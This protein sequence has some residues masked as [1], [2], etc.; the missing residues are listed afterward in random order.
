[1]ANQEKS[2]DRSKSADIN[3]LEADV[4]FFDARLSL[5]CKQRDT[6]YQRAQTKTYEILGHVMS[7]TLQKLRE[8]PKS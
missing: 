2:T 4:A 1:M 8:K 7:G 5:A 6:A 3:A